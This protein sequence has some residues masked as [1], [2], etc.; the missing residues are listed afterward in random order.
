MFDP[1]W[2]KL[3]AATANNE[4]N[5]FARLIFPTVSPGNGNPSGATINLGILG[6]G[7]NG[8]SSQNGMEYQF[9]K[10]GIFPID[11]GLQSRLQNE[12][13]K[14]DIS[15]KDHLS[16]TNTEPSPDSTEEISAF[17]DTLIKRVF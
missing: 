1:F 16:F 11:K 3:A 9:L 7:G 5:T 8:K 17:S 14:F 10:E 12:T 15:A 6:G 4:V 13:S 2:G